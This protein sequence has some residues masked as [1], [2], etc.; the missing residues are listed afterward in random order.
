VVVLDSQADETSDERLL[1]RVG[2]EVDVTPF[3]DKG[4]E[5]SLFIFEFM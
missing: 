2:E 1:I 4:D 5:D 3:D